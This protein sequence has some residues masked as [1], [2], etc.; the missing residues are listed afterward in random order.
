MRALIN[1]ILGL[2]LMVAL[3]VAGGGFYGFLSDDPPSVPVCQTGESPN[4]TFYVAS[5]ALGWPRSL[6][7]ELSLTSGLIA[8]L[9][10]DYEP[11][12]TACGQDQTP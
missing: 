9:V 3:L 4:W 2:Y 8:W 5:R 6:F 7:D 12:E 10:V 1:L 11:F